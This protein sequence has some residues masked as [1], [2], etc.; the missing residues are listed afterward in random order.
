MG[1]VTMYESTKTPKRT[2]DT[3]IDA[4]LPRLLPRDGPER[5]LPAPGAAVCAGGGG[6][7]VRRCVS[8]S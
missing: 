4:R 1:G 2:T 3:I 8:G 5:T 7:A 6:A